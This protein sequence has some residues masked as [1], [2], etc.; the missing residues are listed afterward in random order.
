MVGKIQKF[1]IVGIIIFVALVAIVFV[2][3]NNNAQDFIGSDKVMTAVEITQFEEKYGWTPPFGF[4]EKQLI[5]F[6]KDNPDATPKEL[7]T[8]A[9]EAQFKANIFSDNEIGFSF[10]YPKDMFIMD[11]TVDEN[12]N[13]RKLVIPK[14]YVEEGEQKIQDFIAVVITVSTNESFGLPL[15]WLN[16]PE[17]G[18][19]LLKGYSELDIDG[20]KAISMN[21]ADW[22]VVNTPDNKYQLSIATIPHENPSWLLQNAMKSIVESIIFKKN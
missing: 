2:F 11:G 1:E 17:S 10:N 3:W 20:Q 21:G 13:Y 15:E 6:M 14:S 18:A 5:Q 16:K 4:T 19:D 12:D 7:E 9:K 8:G 22:V